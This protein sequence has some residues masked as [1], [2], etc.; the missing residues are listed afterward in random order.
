MS[1]VIK[2]AT[3]EGYAAGLIKL[4]KTRDDIMVF[5]AD[6]AAATKT[7]SFKKE[8]P[9]SEPLFAC[10]SWLLNPKNEEILGGDSNI[11][12]FMKDFKIVFS[13]EYPGKENLWRIFGKKAELPP[14]ELP[15]ETRMQRAFADWLLKGNKLGAAEGLFYFDPERKETVK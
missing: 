14:E 6:L 15:R 2:K 10:D 11:V 5:D 3:R 13:Y 8:F 12:S 9:D 1:E 4:G 7:G